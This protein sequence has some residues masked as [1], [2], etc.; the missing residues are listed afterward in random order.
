[1]TRGK[2]IQ[3]RL[4]VHKALA[5]GYVCN[6][7]TPEEASKAAFAVVRAMTPAKLVRHY[8]TGR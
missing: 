6:G 2:L 7:M 8:E 4:S 3:V 5:D 1:M